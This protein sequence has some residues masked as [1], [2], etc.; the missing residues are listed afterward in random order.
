MPFTVLNMYNNTIND[1]FLAVSGL[2]DCH[3][4][5]LGN[6]GNAQQRLVVNA[7]LETGNYIVKTVWLPSSQVKLAVVTGDFV[8]VLFLFFFVYNDKN[9]I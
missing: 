1:D 6:S 8:K 4:L 5:V 7:K 3:V 2:K 9:E